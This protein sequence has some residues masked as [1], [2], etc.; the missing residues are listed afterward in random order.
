[1]LVTFLV[2]VVAMKQKGTSKRNIAKGNLAGFGGLVDMSKDG[3]EGWVKRRE[4]FVFK[5]L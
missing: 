5:S 1:M 4:H 3:A 2:L